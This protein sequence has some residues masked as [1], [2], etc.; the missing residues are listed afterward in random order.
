[1][2]KVQFLA[3]LPFVLFLQTPNQ[4]A[5]SQLVFDPPEIAIK[6]RS[7]NAALL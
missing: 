6:F 4:I 2:S 7:L 1:M 5:P 3:F